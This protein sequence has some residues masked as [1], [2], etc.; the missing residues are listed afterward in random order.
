MLIGRDDIS[1]DV[2]TFA[3]TCFSVF[4]YIPLVSTSRWL[5]E[6]W[7]FSRRVATGEFERE[8]KF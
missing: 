7:Q 8:F 3:L 1:N 5:V 6:I 4:V 2:I